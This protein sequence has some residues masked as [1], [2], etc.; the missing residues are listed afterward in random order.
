[1]DKKRNALDAII[2]HLKNSP[3]CFASTYCIEMDE[4]IPTVTIVYEDKPFCPDEQLESC[5]WF[6]NTVAEARIYNTKTGGNWVRECG[7]NRAELLEVINF[8]NAHVF[9][10]YRIYHSPTLCY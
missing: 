3:N 10:C 8:I 2:S 5:L 4:N 9:S 6:H 1:M 7:E